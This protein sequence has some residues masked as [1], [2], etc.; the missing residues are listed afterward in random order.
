MVYSFSAALCYGCGVQIVFWPPYWI[1]IQTLAHLHNKYSSDEVAYEREAIL[2]LA[3]IR[4]CVKCHCFVSQRK[5]YL[6]RFLAKIVHPYRSA[7][8][9]TPVR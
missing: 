6:E 5:K 3:N 7:I 9:H 1:Q 8:P 4:N 2:S